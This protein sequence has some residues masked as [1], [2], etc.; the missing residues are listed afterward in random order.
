MCKM[1]GF[2][3]VLLRKRRSSRLN[4]PEA[5]QRVVINGGLLF[6][7]D[8]SDLIN[9]NLWSTQFTQKCSRFQFTQRFKFT[10][11]EVTIGTRAF[12]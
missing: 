12:K 8:G 4:T 3:A 5:A 11:T 10:P 9:L 7:V 2:A 6:H 1:L